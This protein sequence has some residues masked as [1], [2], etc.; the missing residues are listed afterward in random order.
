MSRGEAV[1]LVMSKWLDPECYFNAHALL[2][3]AICLG[4]PMRKAEVL[5]IVRRYCDQQ[6]ENRRYAR[7][8]Q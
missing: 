2:M 3:Q 6:T 5:E 8:A 7:K 1:K 4:F